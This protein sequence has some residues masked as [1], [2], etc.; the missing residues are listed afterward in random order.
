MLEY[1]TEGDNLTSA[2]VDAIADY[3]VIRII[4]RSYIV[5][6]AVLV[7]FLHAQVKYVETI[8]HL[9]VF[10]HVFHVESIESCLCLAQCSFH[11]ACL[12]HLVRMIRTNPKCLS[13][14]DNILAQSQGETGYALFCLLV[15]DRIIIYGA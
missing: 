1:S 3:L 15:A 10:A 12:Q 6:R 9:E 2:F 13:S 14:I 11:L 5:E 4:G 7:G 8:V